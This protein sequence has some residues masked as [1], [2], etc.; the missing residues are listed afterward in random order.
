MPQLLDAPDTEPGVT[1]GG[2]ERNVTTWVDTIAA[3]RMALLSGGSPARSGLARRVTGSGAYF[4]DL[5]VEV[6]Q[7]SRP[8]LPATMLRPTLLDDSEPVDEVRAVQFV[9]VVEDDDAPW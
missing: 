8:M 1:Y 9:A 6:G 4:A 2:G 3:S 7:V 5:Y